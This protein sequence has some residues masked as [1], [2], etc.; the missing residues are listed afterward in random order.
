MNGRTVTFLDTSSPPFSPYPHPAT[1]FGVISSTSPEVFKYLNNI[2]ALE[3]CYG[4]QRKLEVTMFRADEVLGECELL[5]WAR[6]CQGPQFFKSWE[7]QNLPWVR[8]RDSEGSRT[9]LCSKYH[10][11]Q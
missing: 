3:G 8:L 11:W 1:T 10:C 4:A 5:A 2:L 7:W 9:F 6:P